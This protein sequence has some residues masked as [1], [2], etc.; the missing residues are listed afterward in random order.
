[1]NRRNRKTFQR[2]APILKTMIAIV[3]L[4][5]LVVAIRSSI[6]QWNEQADAIESELARIDR[7]IEL[8][9]QPDLDQLKAQRVALQASVP[10]LS[11]IDWRGVSLSGILYAFGLVPS[12]YVLR[13]GLETLGES[14]RLST[15]LASQVLGHLGKYVP[16]KAMVVVLRVGGLSRDGVSPLPATVSVFMETFMMMSVGAALSCA[17][18][19]GLQV[20]AWIAW[21]AAS[22][23][24]AASIPTA[25]PVLRQ[26]VSRVVPRDVDLEADHRAGTRQSYRFFLVGWIAGLISWCLI[27]LSFGFLVKSIPTVE[28]LPATPSL[29]AIATCAIGL[30]MVIGFASLLP[31]GAGIRELVLTTL[32][33]T[34]VGTAHAMLSAVSARLLFIVVEAIVAAVAWLWLRRQSPPQSTE[35]DA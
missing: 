5:G 7:E 17:I 30:A 12:G 4:V 1:M 25:P 3:V 32:L 19:M 23:A 18:I 22:V 35:S 24:I 33:A 21:S 11:N 2:L 28:P 15:C 8:A 16:G 13:S 31:G 20:P 29:M 6:G 9:S 14:S 27:G 26:I 10:R 34:S